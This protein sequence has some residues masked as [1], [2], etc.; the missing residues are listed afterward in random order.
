MNKITKIR[1]DWANKDGQPYINKFQQPYARVAIQ[2]VETEAKWL[3]G[4]AKSG[5]A[6]LNWKV[7]DEVD[8]QIEEKGQYLNWKHPKRTQNDSQAQLDRI[9]RFVKEIHALIKKDVGTEEEY[10]F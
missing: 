9:E 7:G 3:S 8:I 1:I 2:T 4:F 10:P 5:D 6:A